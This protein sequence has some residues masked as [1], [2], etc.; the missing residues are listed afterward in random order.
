MGEAAEFLVGELITQAQGAGAAQVQVQIESHTSQPVQFEANRLKSIERTESQTLALWV[1]R[2][3][4]P[5]VAVASGAVSPAQL[6]AKALAV[7]DLRPSEPVWLQPGGVRAFAEVQPAIAPPELIPWGQG[8]IDRIRRDFPEVLCQG[9][10]SWEASQTRLVNSEGLDYTY[11]TTALE[12][13]MACEWVRGEDFL[14]VAEQTRT[15]APFD[16]EPLVTRLCQALTWAKH[17]R[18]IPPGRWPVLLTAKAADL[19]WEPL[20]SALNGRQVLEGASPWAHRRGERV[21]HPRLTCR[22]EPQIPWHGCPF[23]DEGILT[24]AFTLIDQGV[25]TRFYTDQYTATQWGEPSSGN[26]FRPGLTRAP[27]PSLVNWWVQPGDLS[28]P[29][30]LRRLDTGLLVDQVLGGGA[31]ISGDFAVNVDLGYWVQGGQV[32]GRVKDTMIAGNV[33]DILQGDMVF[34]SEAHWQDGSFTPGII[35]DQITITSKA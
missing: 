28:D 9:G 35:I 25:L 33:Y 1:W 32:Q 31:D 12:V 20:Q 30:L 6:V 11:R 16:P 18:P 21:A 4:Q 23:D 34:G 22:Q 15:P 5:G 19:L 14:A 3:G 27:F 13:G 2:G 7:A 17:N 26:G 8:M 24:Q 10:L 29:E